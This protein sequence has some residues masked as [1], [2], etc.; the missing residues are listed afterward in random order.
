MKLKIVLS[1]V[2]QEIDEVI[3]NLHAFVNEPDKSEEDE[4]T[5]FLR[6][7][8]LKMAKDRRMAAPFT[9]GLDCE[10]VPRSCVFEKNDEEYIRG[11]RWPMCGVSTEAI[12]AGLDTGPKVEEPKKESGP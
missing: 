9:C 6:S 12:I 3:R 5:E 7:E 2:P 11:H 8:L 10:R 4:L 1:L